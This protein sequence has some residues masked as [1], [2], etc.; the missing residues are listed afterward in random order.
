MKK[1]NFF[2]IHDLQLKNW[3]FRYQESTI[4]LQRW[5]NYFS[6]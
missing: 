1:L 4:H 6:F 2:G 5:K 3:K